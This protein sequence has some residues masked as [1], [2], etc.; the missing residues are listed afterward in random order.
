[1]EEI[2]MKTYSGS[3]VYKNVALDI[4]NKIV[5][6][7]I[8][9]DEKLSGRTTLSSMY[10]VSPETIRRAIALLEDMDVVTSFKGRGIEIL[11][12]SAAEK[13]IEKHKSNEYIFTVKENIYK[14]IEK[15]KQIDDELEQN[16]EKMLDL[17]DRFKNVSPFTFIEI[18]I[19][20]NCKAIG[21][22]VNELKFWQGTGATIIAYRRNNDIVVSPGPTYVFEND[23][24]II[25][26]GSSDAYERVHEYIYS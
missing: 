12:V 9:I 14:L 22:T 4:A 18:E 26:I 11:S 19:K 21:K 25:V 7:E 8:K 20:D 24:I 17:A 1:M 23:D 5:K 2:F 6:G 15:K 13:F 3:S 10:N 16:F